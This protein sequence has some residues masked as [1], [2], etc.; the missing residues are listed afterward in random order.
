MKKKLHDYRQVS[1]TQMLKRRVVC[2]LQIFQ[3]SLDARSKVHHGGS[4]N[5]RG[6]VNEDLKLLN[7]MYLLNES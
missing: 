2:Q 4:G 7:K 3:K 1:K 6:T 5:A